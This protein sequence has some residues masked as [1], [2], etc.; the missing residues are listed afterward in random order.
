[1]GA[2]I[3][4]LSPSTVSR[5]RE[6]E[7]AFMERQKETLNEIRK[8]ID[9]AQKN[10]NR[11]YTDLAMITDDEGEVLPGNELI[12]NSLASSLSTLTVHSN[13]LISAQGKLERL[14][15][16]YHAYEVLKPGDAKDERIKQR[17]IGNIKRELNVEKKDSESNE[18]KEAEQVGEIAE[19]LNELTKEISDNLAAAY[20]STDAIL[21]ASSIPM[22]IKRWKEGQERMRAKPVAYTA[23]K[24][25]VALSTVNRDVDQEPREIQEQEALP[26]LP[27]LGAHPSSNTRSRVRNARPLEEKVY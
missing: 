20:A 17:L 25:R 18:E 13:A 15:N 12:F 11:I 19:S 21:P 2:V 7:K 16:I 3:R 22:D 26:G 6:E 10:R 8:Q 5:R 1:M 14:V 24:Q 27:L 9:E 23:R 4:V